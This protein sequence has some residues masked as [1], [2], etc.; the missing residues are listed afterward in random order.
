[1]RRYRSGLRI[2]SEE[3]IALRAVLPHLAGMLVQPG[4]NIGWD[5]ELARGTLAIIVGRDLG[6]TQ[7]RPVGREDL[8]NQADFDCLRISDAALKRRDHG[9]VHGYAQHQKEQIV[10]D[11]QLRPDMEDCRKFARSGW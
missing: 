2:F 7:Q 4:L 1:M 9:E 3:E 5:L 10:Q 6:Q 8:V 11:D